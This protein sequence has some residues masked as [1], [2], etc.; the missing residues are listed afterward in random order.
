M[1]ESSYPAVLAFSFLNEIMREFIAK[2]ELPKV[3]LVRRPYS[4]IEFDNVIHKTRQRYNKPQSLTTKI[5]LTDLSTEIKLRPPYVVQLSQVEPIANGYQTTINFTKVSVGPPPRLEPLAWH[6]IVT[7]VFTVLLAFVGFYRGLSALSVSSL[8]GYDGPNPMHGWVFLFESGFRFFQSTVLVEYSKYRILES[9]VTLV[10]MCLCTMLVWELRD[11]WQVAACVGSAL[12]MHVSTLVRRLECKLPNYTGTDGNR[13]S[14]KPLQLYPRCRTL[15]TSIMFSQT[16]ITEVVLS[17]RILAITDGQYLRKT[18]KLTADPCE[19]FYTFACGNF[20]K[21]QQVPDGA[22]GWGMFEMVDNATTY[23]IREILEEP[24]RSSDFSALKKAK[25][26]YSACLDTKT[27]DERGLAPLLNVIK[28]AGG[29]PVLS[30]DWRGSVTWHNVARLTARYGIPLFFNM[31]I[32]QSTDNSS[33]YMIVLDAPS[34]RLQLSAKRKQEAVDWMSLTSIKENVLQYLM[35]VV[36]EIIGEA[37]PDVETQLEEV[38]QMANKLQDKNP[39]VKSCEVTVGHLM[40]LHDS[41]DWLDFLLTSFQYSGVTVT[42]DDIVHVSNLEQLENILEVFN[43]SSAKLRANYIM[44]RLVMYLAP[45]TTSRMYELLM[46][47]YRDVV[48]LPTN[49]K[50]W[51][52]CLNKVQDVPEFGLGGALAYKFMKRQ[53]RRGMLQK[54]RRLVNDVKKASEQ[55]LGEANWLD[56]NS[57]RLVK[58]KSRHTTINFG[59]PPWMTNITE[60]NQFYS[61]LMIRKRDHFGNVIRLRR[62]MQTKNMESLASKTHF[63]T[64]WSGTPFMVNAFYETPWNSVSLPSGVMQYPFFSGQYSSVRDVHTTSRMR[65]NNGSV[66]MALDYARLGSL[67]G[68]EMTH[69]FDDV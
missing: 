52:H 64:R 15:K 23:T 47:L 33:N 48:I 30:P 69:A 26:M 32:K 31:H 1:C 46:Q 39:L 11:A 12:A 8:E 4:F 51:Q 2:Y 55:V 61:Q 65:R 53:F 40:S 14:L 21:N 43:S 20:A 41:I 13:C 17:L 24:S 6:G 57:M 67:V 66:L 27:R 44:S 3:N 54:A 35:N 10:P 25:R 45:E 60:L 7:A 58:Q 49:Y 34:M 62:Y 18:V 16:K 36:T 63:Q 22:L 59:F 29:W 68:H 37:P 28:R 5:N 42:P 9:W 50:H 56:T 38:L 19:D